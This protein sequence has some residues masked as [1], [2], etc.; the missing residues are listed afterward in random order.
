MLARQLDQVTVMR[1]QALADLKRK[2]PPPPRGYRNRPT[3]LDD[4]THHPTKAPPAPLNKEAAEGFFD[5]LFQAMREELQAIAPT[6]PLG[7][8]HMKLQ[9]FDPDAMARVRPGDR[10]TPAPPPPAPSPVI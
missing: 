7:R 3:L 5:P 1:L 6:D 10:G 2:P 4:W 9:T 8:R